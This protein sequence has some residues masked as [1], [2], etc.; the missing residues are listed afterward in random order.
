MGDGACREANK[1]RPPWAK[2]RKNDRVFS[3]LR[4]RKNFEIFSTCSDGGDIG[5][6][7][8]GC[9]KAG[10]ACP[11]WVKSR[12]N[13]RVFSSLRKRKNF[14]NFS[15]CSDDE[16]IGGGSGASREAGRESWPW[17]QNSKKRLS[18][19]IPKETEKLRKFFDLLRWRG[20]RRQQQSLRRSR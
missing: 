18:L 16:D 14:E 9:R 4:K 2:S 17:G 7:D 15:T 12:K 6:A 3:S 19:C 8:V 13:D 20:H 11:P 10:M 5:A 1:A